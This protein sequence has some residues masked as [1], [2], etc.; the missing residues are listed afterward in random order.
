MPYNDW[1]GDVA[2]SQAGTVN[3]TLDGLNVAEGCPAGNLNAMGRML[4][5]NMKNLAGTVPVTSNFMLKAGG[6]FTGDILRSGRGGYLHNANAAMPGGKVTIQALG[7][8]LPISP[9]EGDILIEY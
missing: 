3:V 6:T 5:A 7:G 9:Q 2:A 1:I 4:M 8:A